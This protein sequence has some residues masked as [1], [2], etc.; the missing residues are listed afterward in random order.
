M[1]TVSI[2]STNMYLHN[3]H[4]LC[5]SINEGGSMHIFIEVVHYFVQDVVLKALGAEI[6]R[7]PAAPF[8]TPGEFFCCNY[9]K[10]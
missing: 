5:S 4:S 2:H 3:E 8:G 10:Y 7:V 6:I 1:V 9:N